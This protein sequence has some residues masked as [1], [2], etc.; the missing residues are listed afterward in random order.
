MRAA[1]DFPDYLAARWTTLV[2]V[3]LLLGA[4]RPVAEQVTAVALGR[5]R[6]DWR[7]LRTAADLDAEV[8]EVLLATWADAR[9][10]QPD[11]T[12][13]VEAPAVE[14]PASEDLDRVGR[15]LGALSD[16]ERQRTVVSALV[17][18]G[19]V[20]ADPA[21]EEEVRRAAADLLVGGAPPADS[22]P[23]RLRP[24]R[25]GRWLAAGAAVLALLVAA[26]YLLGVVRGDPPDPDREERLPAVTV[27]REANPAPL[28]WWADGVLH[29]PRTSVELPGVIDLVEVP[30]GAVVTDEDHRV[31]HVRFDGGRTVLGRQ[32]PG[33][34]LAVEPGSALVAWVEPEHDVV[35]HDLAAGR[36]V[37]RHTLDIFDADSGRVVAVDGGAVLLTSSFGDV[38]WLG[39]SAV[40]AIEQPPVLLDR[41]AGTVLTRLDGRRLRMQQPFFSVG[42]T[43]RGRA[44]QVSPDGR[45]VLTAPTTVGGPAS[46]LRLRDAA[47]G[48]VLAT[49]LAGDAGDAGDAVDAVVLASAF[50]ASGRTLTHLLRRSPEAVELVTCRVPGPGRG[51]CRVDATLDGGPYGVGSAPLLATS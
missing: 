3:V 42:F 22:L 10:H 17:G 39:G 2:R 6:R 1:D 49:G 19:A 29:L 4:P 45:H 21:L 50:G 20:P 16:A 15:R 18:T 11:A 34:G 32:V 25:T 23:T 13:A 44:G 40:S 33:S 43:V 47:S 31:V 48:R 24:P 27:R 30:D 46:A 12:A 51:A 36:D 37:G 38:R 7:E 14:V 26:T 8:V 28:A 35:L 41:A 9:R 5:A